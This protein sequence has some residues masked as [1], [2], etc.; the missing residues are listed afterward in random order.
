MN[1]VKRI[2]ELY[3]ETGRC[4]FLYPKLKKISLNGGRMLNINEAVEAMIRTIPEHRLEA[5]KL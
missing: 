3:K 4:A 1:K 2:I 5:F